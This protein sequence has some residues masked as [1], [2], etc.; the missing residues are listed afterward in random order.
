MKLN[1]VMA[2]GYNKQQQKRKINKLFCVL[3]LTLSANI[4]FV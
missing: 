1:I 3:N 2:N 4:E